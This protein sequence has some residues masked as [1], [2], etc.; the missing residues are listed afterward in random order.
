MRAP[1]LRIALA[2]LDPTVG[3]LAGNSCLIAEAAKRARAAGADLLVTPELCLPGYPAEDLYLKRHFADA[4]RRALDELAA[5]IEGIVVTVG[6]A[7]P[8]P[9]LPRP[10]LDAPG[11][12][13]A[14]NS[15]AVIEAGEVRAVYR[16]NR[17]P[18]YGVF[19]EARYF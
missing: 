13:A 17:L 16:K 15:L 18:N 6:F 11:P 7:E 9:R 3:D 2:Q 19:D 12:P 5:A 1:G 4:N 8:G 10:S 14:H